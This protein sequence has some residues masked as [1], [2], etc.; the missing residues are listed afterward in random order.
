M[1]DS[2]NTIKICRLGG[3]I[4]MEYVQRT[5]K[6]TIRPTEGAA[7]VLWGD[8]PKIAALG[9]DFNCMHL[10]EPTGWSTRN[11]DITLISKGIDSAGKIKIKWNKG[12]W[13]GDTELHGQTA[14]TTG[15]DSGIKAMPFPFR[16]H[17]GRGT[18]STSLFSENALCFSNS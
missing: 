3:G 13:P 7:E 10:N 18:L 15:P 6:W 12:R 4:Q 8:A 2:L 14:N 1:R 17:S 5:G 9:A 11:M 16:G